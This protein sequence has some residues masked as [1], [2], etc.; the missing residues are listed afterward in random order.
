[1]KV[2][3]R[4]AV[5]AETIYH[6]FGLITV[7]Q[8]HEVIQ[9][10]HSYVDA[11]RTWVHRLVEELVYDALL[12]QQTAQRRDLGSQAFMKAGGSQVK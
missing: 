3:H 11:E 8:P 9:A 2:A 10:P 7:E 1:M 5:R 12:S 4:D 6:G